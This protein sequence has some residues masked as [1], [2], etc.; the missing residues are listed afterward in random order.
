MVERGF[1]SSWEEILCGHMS[2]AFQSSNSLLCYKFCLSS[3]KKVVV[4]SISNLRSF[5]QAVKAILRPSNFFVY[6]QL[7]GFN[8]YSSDLLGDL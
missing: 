8:A 2:I 3:L 7:L 5:A 1:S 6:E 4:F